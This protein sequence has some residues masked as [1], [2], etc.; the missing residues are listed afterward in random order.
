MANN[1]S[2]PFSNG[3][4][5]EDF[6]YQFCERCTKYKEREDGFPE[7]PENGGCQILDDLEY[8]RFDIKRWP[9]TKLRELTNAKTGN[10]IAWHYCIGF[11]NA[12]YEGVMVPYFTLM[13]K[14]LFA[15]WEERD[16]ENK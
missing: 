7:F 9:S 3:S 16:D 1:P 14:A 15:D 11:E 12:D 10:P 6:K 13:S 2:L 5:Y 4:E 8:A